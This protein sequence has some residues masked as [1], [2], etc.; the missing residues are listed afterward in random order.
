[1][2]FISLSLKNLLRSKIRTL[3]TI[4]SVVVATIVVFTVLSLD[5]GYKSA[6]EEELV[7]K[8]GIHLYISK[9][10]CP[11]EAAS[12]I[13]QGGASPQFVGT[14]VI[15]TIRK[16]KS[17]KYIKEIMPFSILAIT[18]PDGSRTDIF[19][20]ATEAIERI[21]PNWRLKGSWFKDTNSIILGQTIA[22]LEKREIGDKIFFEQFNR[23]FEV[24]GILEPT[25]TQDD[26]T[27]FLPLSVLLKLFSREGKLSGIGIQ[28]TSLAHLEEVKREM[29]QVLPAEYFLLPSETLSKGVL[30]F[31][32]STK[33]IMLVMVV[34]A[35]G[36]CIF[37]IMNTF[38]MTIFERRKEFGYIRCVGASSFDIIHLVLLETL[39]LISVGVAFGLLNGSLL[40][41]QFENY[42]RR[43]LV[44]F[45]PMARIVRPSL[46]LALITS[47][48]VTA[49][50]LLS[51][52]YPALRAARA[53]PMEAVRNE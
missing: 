4:L 41:P 37:A 33:A 12:I 23:E 27:F 31:F 51:S 35:L 15:D 18:T 24:V 34:I 47:A 19:F 13:V 11:M 53:I 5:R 25:Y 36:M 17:A 45:V 39:I 8:S 52:L 32:G 44:S 3:L 30:S 1:M 7:K 16:I 14:G 2:S 46:S 22:R 28:L 29:R 6:V 42:I 10:G 21:R 50:G 20:G 9:E 38:L 26:G 40:T 43:F 49:V 48:L